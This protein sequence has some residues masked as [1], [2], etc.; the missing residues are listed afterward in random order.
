MSANHR[1]ITVFVAR[2]GGLFQASTMTAEAHDPSATR[3]A[4]KCAALHFGAPEDTIEITPAGEHTV[5]AS[6]REPARLTRWPLWVA[7]AIAV[8]TALVCTAVA[9]I[10]RGGI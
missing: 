5:I 8:V 2:R 3:A 7:V 9:L 6:V 1:G 10:A 4:L